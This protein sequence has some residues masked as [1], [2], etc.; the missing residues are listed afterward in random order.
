MVTRKQKLLNE[1]SC[2]YLCLMVVYTLLREVIVFDGIIGSS[3][4][5][6]AFFGIG[7]LLIGARFFF[8][9]EYFCVK[10][11]WLLVAFIAV[12]V[13]STLIN[14]RFDFISNVKAI[15]WMCVFFFICYPVGHQSKEER[16]RNIHAVFVTSII[17]MTVLLLT[18]LPM[19]FMHIGYTYF[20]G[21][22]AG[23][24]STQGFSSMYM[25]LWGI[26]IEP[27]R[28]AVYTLA[29]LL[30]AIYLFIKNKKRG[31]RILL[32]LF[33]VL[34][35]LYIVLSSSRTAQAS[36][37]A[38][39]GWMAFYCCYT[40]KEQ[41]PLKK[42]LLSVGSGVLAVL[43]CYCTIAALSLALPYAKKGIRT[44]VPTTV[45]DSVHQAYDAAYKASGLDVKYGYFD[46]S[47]NSEE[48]EE[49]LE[50]L[51]RTDMEEK[52][53]ISNGR[54]L[55][56]EE[57]IQVF[58]KAPI[59]GT[60]PRGVSSF[61]KLHAPNTTLAKYDRVIHNAFLEVLAG[62]GA[63]GFLM[64]FALLLMVAVA[65]LKA[66]FKEQYN[67]D[68]LIMGALALNL[69][70]CGLLTSDLFF[71]LTF[72]GIIFWLTL[73]NVKRDKEPI[74]RKEDEEQELRV[75]V[76]GLKDPV[77]GVEKIVVDYVRKLTAKHAIT[78]DF[79]I[80]GESFSM[81][82]ELTELGCR[83]VYVPVRRSDPK[84]YKKSMEA[85]FSENNYAAVW[86]NYSGLTN[87]D[88]LIKAKEYGV[89][90]R[91]AHSH[92]TR[93]Y[94]GNAIMKYVVIALHYYNKVR[95]SNYATHFW[96]C[97]ELSGKFMFPKAVHKR[98]TLVNNA[99]DTAVFCPKDREKIRTQFG[100][101]N[102]KIVIGH[103]ARMCEA[104]N[105]LFL[106]RVFAKIKEINP[107]SLLLFVGDGELREQIES[108]IEKLGIG[109]SV[110][111][112]GTRSDVSDLL[113][114]M[115]VFVLPSHSE[116]LGL[117]AIEAQACGIPC[118]VSAAVPKAVDISGTVKFF[119]VEEPTEFW[120]ESILS[121][122]GKKIQ[123]P[124]DKVK[125][126]GYEISDEVDK[127]YM[128]FVGGAI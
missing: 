92:V 41:K 19:Y 11:I 21:N 4:L 71:N 122:V 79:L 17:T 89:P 14:F 76:Y 126:G 73:G 100:I 35:V 59:F 102:D 30:M 105:Q 124:T 81:E 65:L 91:I 60:S 69:V 34:S 7:L 112:T 5:S 62:V 72:G 68:T 31:I 77:G 98:I 26:F 44:V 51:H 58:L 97:S 80:F 119:S 43:L 74:C 111:L 113:N 125:A 16:A 75:L 121:L 10:N 70:I 93:L 115:D 67:L 23:T 55:R 107:N 9:R 39:G 8:D 56:W 99:V 12:S 108:E 3:L 13:L 118:V 66:T 47:E 53:D 117:S 127:I 45:E 15:G 88:L 27:N 42:L 96:A 110:M 84:G 90:V 48:D 36:L 94:W 63:V 101:D 20:N 2:I 114:A 64:I 87:I 86:G 32:S 106:L 61:A 49:E 37:F 78:F 24:Y 109:D 103:V 120:A 50:T 18:S 128:E 52:D 6:Y 85:V 22:A 38:V 25:R 1:T 46:P 33:G 82:K 104:K 95:I 83:C 29:V 28:A 123:T 57:G 54:F 116:G 40:R